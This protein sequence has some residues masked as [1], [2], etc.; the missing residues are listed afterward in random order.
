MG[1]AK[2]YS[3]QSKKLISWVLLGCWMVFIFLS[4]SIPGKNIPLLF[5]YQDILY[6][7]LIY[8]ILGL[9]F[10][11]A[12]KLTFLKLSK[13]ELLVIAVI[14]SIIFGI[15]DEIHQMFVPARTASLE[16]LI[17]D[18]VASYIGVILARVDYYGSSKRV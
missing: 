9:L 18:S 12:L 13:T 16:D 2:Q 8:A 5:P 4:S 3:Y 1:A 14:C 6:H 11:R 7:A 17:I 15:T 10:Y